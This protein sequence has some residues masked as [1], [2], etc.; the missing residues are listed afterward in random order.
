MQ[1]Q[2]FAGPEPEVQLLQRHRRIVQQLPALQ[3]GLPGVEQPLVGG[4]VSRRSSA[5]RG[6]ARCA[7]AGPSPMN[8]ARRQYARVVPGAVT[9]AA[10]VGDLVV[11]EAMGPE[12]AVRQSGTPPRSGPRPPESPRPAR[13]SGPAG[14]AAS[15]VSPYSERCSGSSANARSRSAPSRA[16]GRR[17]AEDQVEREVVRCRQQR[18]ASTAR[19]P[20]RRCGCGASTGARRD[21]TTGRRAKPGSP[22]RLARRPRRLGV[23][24]SGLASRVI[25]AS[26]AM[27]GR[28]PMR[29]SSRAMAA[30]VTRD[31]VPPPK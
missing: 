11:L 31:G 22:R 17:Q 1:R 14:Y 12:R 21:R 26:A 4:P 24:S 16:R 30:G 6:P 28:R 29:S 25:S 2:T 27:A 15:T 10:G 8:G 20:G 23:T 3:R 9:R 18:S 13:S 19:G 7:P 5:A